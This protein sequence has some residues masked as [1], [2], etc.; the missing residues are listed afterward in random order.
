MMKGKLN[1]YN[2]DIN[3]PLEGIKVLP[4]VKRPPPSRERLPAKSPLIFRQN[5]ELNFGLLI[6]VSLPFYRPLYSR[7]YRARGMIHP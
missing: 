3:Q 4:P 7:V 5:G 2:S 6:Y 1:M